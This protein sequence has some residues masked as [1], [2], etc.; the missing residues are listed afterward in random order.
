MKKIIIIGMAL[1]MTSSC[2]K[3]PNIILK[4]SEEEAAAIPYQMGQTVN[5]LDQDG[6]TLAFQVIRD[7]TYPYSQEPLYYAVHDVDV[8]EPCQYDR[9]ARTVVM[10]C[11]QDAKRLGFTVLPKKDFFFYFGSYGSSFSLDVK[12]SPND[13]VT[14]HDITHENVQ[15][16]VLYDQDSDVPLY[17]WYYNEEFG[18][19]YF[20]KG[21]FELTRIP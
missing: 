14:I 10:T 20:R 13:V 19:L 4:L 21:D 8:V 9:Y 11:E 18:L 1:I 3:H 5:F 15:H 12:L 17:D 6:D 7:I 2:V 16:E